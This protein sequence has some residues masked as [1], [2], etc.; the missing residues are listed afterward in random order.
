MHA[1]MLFNETFETLWAARYMQ[2]SLPEEMKEAFPY[3]R[4]DHHIMSRPVRTESLQPGPGCTRGRSI[5]P[6]LP[7]YGETV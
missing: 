5:E 1:F 4:D 2:L 6:S 3:R 7:T